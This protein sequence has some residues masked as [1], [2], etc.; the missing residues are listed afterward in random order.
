MKCFDM[1]DKVLLLSQGQVVYFGDVHNV[2]NYFSSCMY[3]FSFLNS[4]TGGNGRSI[5]DYLLDIS[6]GKVRDGLNAKNAVDASEGM[7]SSSAIIDLYYHSP[8]YYQLVKQIVENLSVDQQY[9][10]QTHP[11]NNNENDNNMINAS[12][13]AALP[14]CQRLKAIFLPD[15]DDPFCNSTTQQI[16]LLLKRYYLRYSR[17]KNWLFF[18]IC[19]IVVIAILHS[20]VFFQLPMGGD[21]TVYTYRFSLFA[22]L[23]VFFLYAHLTDLSELQ[24]DRV[25]FIMNDMLPRIQLSRIGLRIWYK[26]SSPI[27]S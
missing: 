4:T 23:L 14:L 10:A 26:S 5:P 21:V 17:H 3:Q 2:R 25:I 19:K 1:F 7:V 18:Q 27:V 11:Q 22:S 9:E 16:Q 24:N 13:I 20:S 8:E 6:S 15:Y 12:T